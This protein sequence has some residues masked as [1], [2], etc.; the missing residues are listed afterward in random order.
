MTHS[1]VR[2]VRDLERT[3]KWCFFAPGAF[4]LYLKDIFFQSQT[5]NQN[6]ILK[7]KHQSSKR[8]YGCTKEENSYHPRPSDDP[9]LSSSPGKR[10]RSR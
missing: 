9:V 3:C 5:D 4:V 10:P 1:R 2:V 8:I 7:E 6:T